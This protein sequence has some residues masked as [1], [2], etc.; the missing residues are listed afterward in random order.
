MK[1]ESINTNRLAHT[2]WN[3]K[4][5]TVFAPKYRRKV[6]LQEKRLGE[7]ETVMR[8]GGRNHRGGKMSRT[9][10]SVGV[11]GYYIDT[12]G[13]NTKVMKEYRTRKER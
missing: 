8:K 2:K 1:K 6:S 11:R 3:G 9:H 4:D 5:P 12:V 7:S 13:K 10:P